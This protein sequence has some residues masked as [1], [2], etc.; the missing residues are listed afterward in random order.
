MRIIVVLL[1]LSLVLLPAA[2]D[3]RCRTVQESASLGSEKGTFPLYP[4]ERLVQIGEQ[5]ENPVLMWTGYIIGVPLF[6]P[7]AAT[8]MLGAGVGA[9]SHPW[10]KCIETEEQRMPE[11]QAVKVLAEHHE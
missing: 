6:V 5:R 3:A 9:L 8:A 7:A 10:T 4:A 2:G 11:L 1:M